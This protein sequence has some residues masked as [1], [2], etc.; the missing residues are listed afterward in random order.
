MRTIRFV[1]AIVVSLASMA[2]AGS[3]RVECGNSAWR[4]APDDT[5]FDST[6]GKDPRRYPPDPQ[7]DF[8][9]IKLDLRMPDPMSRRFDCIETITFRTLG[10][11]IQRLKLNA[12]EL[13]IKK[14]T[15][16]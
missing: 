9:H 6:T 16:L 13:D 5:N 10:R 15:D 8:Q 3:Q 12:V 7:V 4:A 1:A 14:V 2:P 11:P